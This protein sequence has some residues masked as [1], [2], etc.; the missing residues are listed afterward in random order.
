MF[1]ISDLLRLLS[2]FRFGG[3]YLDMDVLLMRSLEDIPLNYVGAETNISVGNS[4][5]SLEPDGFGHHV[6]ELFLRNFQ[7][8]YDGDR[9]AYN[10]PACLVRVLSK[11]CDTKIFDKLQN[12]RETCHG[13][14]V[15]NINAFYEINWDEWKYF[16]E[17]QHA[18]STLERTKES[19]LIH[20]W[21]HL[22]AQWPLKTDS[23]AA[24]I[25]LAQRNCPRVLAASGKYFI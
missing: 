1:N 12:S 23:N 19:Y 5:I 3:I 22:N 24:Y 25:Q 16:F 21:N 7:E 2:L 14:E 8:N 18:N 4:V 6:G 15:F 17:E 11:L 20:L 13:F 9:W 10:G